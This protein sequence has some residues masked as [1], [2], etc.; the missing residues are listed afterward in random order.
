MSNSVSQKSGF[1][2]ELESP[3]KGPMA[4]NASKRSERRCGGPKR[5]GIWL[6]RVGRGRFSPIVAGLVGNMAGIMGQVASIM[7]GRF[8]QDDT[9][10]PP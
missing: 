3:R 4:V 6:R 7:R 10:T 1:P 5:L 9:N 8:P 2:K